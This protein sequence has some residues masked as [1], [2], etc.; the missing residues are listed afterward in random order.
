MPNN[1][2]DDTVFQ[3]M[4]LLLALLFAFPIQ[5]QT[6]SEQ[7][8]QGLALAKALKESNS[9]WHDS[10][11]TLE[12]QLY[13]AKGEATIHRLNVKSLEGNNGEDKNLMV[14]DAPKDVKGTAFLSYSHLDALD[15]QWIYLPALKRVK[16]IASRTKSGS[17]MGSE[18]SYEDLASFSLEKYQFRYLDDKPCGQLQCALLE[19]IPQ[20][21]YSGYSRVI[22]WL[23]S[24]FKR[25]QKVEY[26]DSKGK[27]LKIMTVQRYL[28]LQ[29]KHWRAEQAEIH[30][31]QT[32]KKTVLIW[33]NIR[34]N[35]GL[36]EADFGQN[37]LKNAD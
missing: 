21:V 10:Q 20:D 12:M 11:S 31:M 36:S 30:N 18:L 33:Q 16:R 8:T 17:F 35:T 19:A 5:A 29:D 27:L 25:P 3:P 14:F 2:E 28:L 32:E 9:G 23:D 1:N 22:F 15:E 24:E 6:L 13:N 34:L 37:T 26:F 7:Q 4:V